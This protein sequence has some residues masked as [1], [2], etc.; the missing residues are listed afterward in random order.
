MDAGKGSEASLLSESTLWKC[1]WS[2]TCSQGRD[3]KDPTKAS[4]P[5]PERPEASAFRHSRHTLLPKPHLPA[6]SPSCQH[7]GKP[8]EQK[9]TS[10]APGL[11]G[12]AACHTLREH[13]LVL[14]RCTANTNTARARPKRALGTRH[15]KPHS[16]S[17]P[18][19]TLLP[20]RDN[21]PG[22]L[23]P[24]PCPSCSLGL[25]LVA[26]PQP[27]GS[28]L[29]GQTS[30]W[31]G[32]GRSPRGNKR[33]CEGISKKQTVRAASC[34]RPPARSTPCGEILGVRLCRVTIHPGEASSWLRGARCSGSRTKAERIKQPRRPHVCRL[35]DGREGSWTCRAP[36]PALTP[37]TTVMHHFT[38][39]GSSSGFG[40]GVFWQSD[41]SHPTPHP[42]RL[43]FFI[44][45]S[46]FRK[47]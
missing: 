39:N 8:R 3:P 22:C 45:F 9:A 2:H 4:V 18:K 5:H 36:E 30:C 26:E 32:K 23:H 7:L 24:P 28:A 14:A 17:S 27:A 19:D 13:P 43:L 42:P 21:K 33:P 35:T 47:H 6:S 31:E 41:F 20:R 38:D 25:N 34:R 16:S 46:F 15:H 40:V 44:C 1:F 29:L 11:P 37:A 12:A 10:V